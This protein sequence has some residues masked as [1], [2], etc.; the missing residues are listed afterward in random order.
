MEINKANKDF[1][2]KDKL[3]TFGLTLAN[4]EKAPIK[5][6][7]LILTNIF[8]SPN[9]MMFML[10]NHYSERLKDNIFAIVGSSKILGNPKNFVNHLGT[11]VQDFFYKPMQGMVNGPLEGGKGL[12]EGTKSL[13]KNTV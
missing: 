12:V 5:I 3:K 9:E 4:A 8:S 11:G 7:S 6:N 13:F 10:E 2:V 1:S